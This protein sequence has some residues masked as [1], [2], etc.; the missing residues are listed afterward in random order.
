MSTNLLE[1]DDEAMVLVCLEDVTQRKRTEE[2]LREANQTL[3]A[4]I[5][6]SPLAIVAVDSHKNI[7]KWNPAAERIFGWSEKEI[8]GKP[9]PIIPKKN[10]EEF[11][12]LFQN[13]LEGKTISGLETRRQKKDGTLI[14]VSL[15]TAPLYGE[16]LQIRGSIAILEDIAERKKTEKERQK[17]FEQL[18]T[19][20]ERLQ[21]LSRRL[22]EL[23]ETERRDLARELHDEVGQNLTALSINLNIIQ[24]LIPGESA[25]KATDR[26]NDS[27]RLVEE[28]V[29][30]I[31]DVMARLR[32]PVLDDYGLAAAL[33]WYSGQFMKRN[34]IPTVLILKG[35]E[36]AHR[37]PLG[38]ETAMF[39]IAQ[40]ALNNV[41][42]H[43]KASQVTLVL[44][45]RDESVLLVITDNGGGFD[46]EAHHQ[47]G[48]QPEW[49]LI[50]MRERA[51][52]IGGQFQI[53]TTPGKGTKIFVEVYRKTDT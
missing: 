11:R 33:N 17:L 52:S 20:R 19:G 40:E 43:A 38:T 15:S 26:I 3:Q 13:V 22:V 16:N 29:V 14:D 30:R 6:A 37:L 4:L 34:G 28:T 8:L 36:W 1:M 12:E 10:E 24:N 2:A 31:R 21:E 45:N 25:S 53:E 35:E 39:R 18:R 47:S 51:H 48:A 46:P 50:N 41:A 44:E 23:Q 27:Q 9:T 49:G 42:K 7:L 32:P 5:Q